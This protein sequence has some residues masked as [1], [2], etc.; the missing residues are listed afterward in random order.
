[1]RQAVRSVKRHH[2]GLDRTALVELVSILW[3]RRVFE[4]RMMAVLLLDAFEPLLQP[5]DMT[6]WK[7]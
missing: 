6:S 5:A 2:G 1:M 4:R 7:G 3:S